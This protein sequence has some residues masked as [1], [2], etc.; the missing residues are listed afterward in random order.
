MSKRKP[1]QLETYRLPR[2]GMDPKPHLPDCVSLNIRRPKPC[3]CG[4]PPHPLPANRELYRDDKGRIRVRKR[5]ASNN[6]RDRV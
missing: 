3:D 1:E 2:P 5:R 6:R 4:R